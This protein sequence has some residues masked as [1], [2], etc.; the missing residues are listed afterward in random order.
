MRQG[1]ALG[2]SE[3]LLPSHVSVLITFGV[4][5]LLDQAQVCLLYPGGY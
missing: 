4:K 5:I 1:V 3:V 2:S